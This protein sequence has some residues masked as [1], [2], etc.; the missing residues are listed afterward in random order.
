MWQQTWLAIFPTIPSFI[1]CIRLKNARTPFISLNKSMF[2]ST[3]SYSRFTSTYKKTLYDVFGMHQ[4]FLLIFKVW[5]WLCL[6]L[7]IWTASASLVCLQLPPIQLWV[8]CI[9]SVYFFIYR[10]HICVLGF[11]DTLYEYKSDHKRSKMTIFSMYSGMIHF[12]FTTL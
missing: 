8:C 7:V 6:T 3:L 5:R 12:I 4:Q 2:R 10:N 11:M 9:F 1:L